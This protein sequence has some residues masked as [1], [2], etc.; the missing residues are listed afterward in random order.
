[1]EEDKTC[2]LV[3]IGV[4][5]QGNQELVGLTDGFW[6]SKDS[7]LKLLQDLKLNGLSMS[8]N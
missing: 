2:I 8:L 5:A 6:E 4:D 1:M 3:I 7:G